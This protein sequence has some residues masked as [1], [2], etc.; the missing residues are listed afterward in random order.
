MSLHCSELPCT[1]LGHHELECIN[2]TISGLQFLLH[3]NFMSSSC[4]H[5]AVSLVFTVVT[6]MTPVPILL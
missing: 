2:I 4:A 1:Y 5:M 6:I 3:V